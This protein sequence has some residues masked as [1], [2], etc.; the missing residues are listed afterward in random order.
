MKSPYPILLII[1][2][3][4]ISDLSSQSKANKKSFK[5]SIQNKTP[6][7]RVDS[8]I[9]SYNIKNGPGF[10]FAVIKDGAIVYKKG[11]GVA[12][13]EYGIPITPTTVFQVASLSK[14]FT[15]FSILLLEQEGKLSIDDDI[16]KY[17]TEMPDYGRTITL[18]NLA[19]HT[20]GIRDN[21]NLASLIGIGEVDMLSNEQVLKLI[22]S[23]KGLNFIPGDEFEYCN[24]GYILLAEIVKRVS[25]LSFSE[26][27]KTRIFKPLNM[28]NSQFIDD[29]ETIIGNRAYSYYNSDSIYRKSILNHTFVG[30]TGLNTTV[31][32]LS[33]WSL[34][35]NK[36]TIGND[37]IY[38]KMKGK[39]RLNNGEIIPYALGQ[40]NKV[41]KGLNVIFHGGGI[42]GYGSYL[43]RIPEQN[44]AIAYMCNSQ[45]YHPFDVVYNIADY[46]LKDKEIMVNTTSVLKPLLL[47]NFVGSYEPFPGLIISISEDN[48]TLFLQSKGDSSK[49]KLT[50]CSDYEFIYPNRPHSRIVFEKTKGQIANFM[51]WHFSDF[52]Y[53]AP[54]VELKE[55][56]ESK[57]NLN[58]IV[59]KYYNAEVNTAYDFV[60]M[61]NKLIAK[62]NINN[63]IALITLQPD[64]FV[65]N[66]IDFFGKIEL[67]RNEQQKVIG[68]YISGQKTKR[69]KFEKV[70]IN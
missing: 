48:G 8:L 56:D 65:S 20:S 47:Q 6:S 26:F 17:L 19:N 34:N 64:V 55:F 66:Y 39:S 9:T 15:V 42:A 25:G 40:E 44:F 38:N 3:L 60:I 37:S 11:V 23:Q 51:K 16:R 41:H 63:D 43:L 18:R 32:D 67:I 2:I 21:T 54:R 59:G 57:V 4:Q 46:Y 24:S 35:F 22:M 1:F 31:E 29:P 27:T 10:A 58:E 33:L 50:Q 28:K 5:T 36:K 14:Q 7:E 13:L 70:T 61:E 49:V 53:K 12:N 52:A 45:F 69:I 68:C 30:S 62:H